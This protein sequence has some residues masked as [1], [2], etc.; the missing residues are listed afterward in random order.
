LIQEDISLQAFEYR[1]HRFKRYDLEAGIPQST[2]QGVKTTIRADIDECRRP[3][4]KESK[5]PG[6]FRLVSIESMPK[7]C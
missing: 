3:F 1:R 4:K 7:E 6:S 2:Q 5:G